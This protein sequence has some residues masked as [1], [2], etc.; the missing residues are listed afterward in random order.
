MKSEELSEGLNLLTDCKELVPGL[1]HPD[2]V[3]TITKYR[4]YFVAMH[5]TDQAKIPKQYVKPRRCRTRIPTNNHLRKKILRFIFKLPPKDKVAELKTL[6]RMSLHL[7]DLVAR[8][9]LSQQV[10]T[11]KKT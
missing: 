1:L 7:V 2:V 9:Q 3:A 10:S 8:A 5:L 6:T 11:N 4:A